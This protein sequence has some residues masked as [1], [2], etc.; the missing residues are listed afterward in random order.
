MNPQQTKNFKAQAEKEEIVLK[1]YKQ[2]GREK[3]DYELSIYLI[4]LFEQ[5]FAYCLFFPLR[6]EDIK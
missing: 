2:R 6:H 3:E 1:K 4:Y 5:L